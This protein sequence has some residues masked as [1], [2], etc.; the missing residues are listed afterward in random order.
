MARKKPKSNHSRVSF[1][2][3]HQGRVRDSDLTRQFNAGDQESLADAVKHERVSGKGDLT[4]K[5]TVVGVNADAPASSDATES[6]D[7]ALI[8]GRVLRAH[9]LHNTVLADDGRTFECSIRQ[10][11]KSLSIDGRGTVVAGDRVQFR[12]EAET[13]SEST[14]MI[15]FV[16]P[17]HGIISRQ[18]RGQQHIIAANVDH[19]LIVTS[20]AEPTLKPAL[21]D[22]FLLSAEQCGL[23]PVVIINKCD[24]VDPASLQPILG[25]YASLGYRVLLT[26]ADRGTNIDYLKELLKGKQTAL[27]GQSGV[28][29]SSLLNAVQPGLGLAVSEVSKDNQKGRHTTTTSTLIP[30]QGEDAGWVFDTPGIR[31][32]QL[33]DITA[34]EVAGLMPDLRPHVG[35]C[36][37]ANCLHLSEDDCAVKDAVADGRIDARRYD[38]YCHLLEDDL[39]V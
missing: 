31:Q 24:L 21:I 37:Y 36:R 6:N 33:W 23:N 25:V 3:R 12:C 39:L 4:R 8:S 16:A 27:S 2:K 15:E 22:R 7:A 13:E 35:A 14:G 30:L 1:R 9:G 5:R 20:A 10:V 28:G 29:K 19:L 18:S 26:S 11:L 17:R 32:F 38:S 34:E